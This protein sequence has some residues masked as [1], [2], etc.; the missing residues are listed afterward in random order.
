[1]EGLRVF[2]VTYII[3][4]QTRFWLAYVT[5]VSV[6]PHSVFT[7]GVHNLEQVLLNRS[8]QPYCIVICIVMN[9]I[10]LILMGCYA[11]IQYVYYFDG[12]LCSDSIHVLFGWA[13]MLGFNTCTILMG[14]YAR[15]QYIHDFRG[16]YAR[17]QYM[18]Y[19]DGL[20]CSY[21]IHVLF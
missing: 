5:P 9:Y 16:C 10:C 13:V 3:S 7:D 2:H 12:R 17:I 21:S 1:M 20:L 14:C 15:I 8:T 19:F 4:L 18:Y 11:R 6:I